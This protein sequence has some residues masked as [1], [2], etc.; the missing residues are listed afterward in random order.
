VRAFGAP[1]R[2]VRLH[3]RFEGVLLTG[4]VAFQVVGRGQR[5]SDHVLQAQDR[6]FHRQNQLTSSGFHEG[7]ALHEGFD[8]AAQ[9]GQRR[10]QFVRD[11]LHE[12]RT[13]E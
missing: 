11:D 8:A 9:H 3:G 5:H 6:A 13:L 4:D 10:T 7:A 2:R 1:L 12:R